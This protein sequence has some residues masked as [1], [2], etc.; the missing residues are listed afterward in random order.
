[1]VVAAVV[2]VLLVEVVVLLRGEALHPGVHEVWYGMFEMCDDVWGVFIWWCGG[3]D[4]AVAAISTKHPSRATT[5][6]I[7]TRHAITA[8]TTE[9]NVPRIATTIRTTTGTAV[10]TMTTEAD[11]IRILE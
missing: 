2:L 9:A 3:G 5:V 4:D 1:M 11:M 10:T 6:R 7:A 8:M